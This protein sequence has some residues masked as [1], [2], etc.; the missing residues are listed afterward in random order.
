MP[1]EIDKEIQA[2]RSDEE[3]DKEDMSTQRHYPH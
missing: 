1:I 3:Q 2:N